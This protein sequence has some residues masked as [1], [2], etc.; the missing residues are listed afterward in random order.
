MSLLR[1]TV[2]TLAYRASQ[3]VRGAPPEFAEFEGL[4]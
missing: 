3:A 1:H 4:P 2:A